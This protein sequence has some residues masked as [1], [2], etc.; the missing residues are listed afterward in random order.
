MQ[1]EMEDKDLKLLVNSLYI[2]IYI[3]MECNRYLMR[4]MEGVWQFH[5]MNFCMSVIFLSQMDF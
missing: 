1:L 5:M 3:C 4:R 2:Y